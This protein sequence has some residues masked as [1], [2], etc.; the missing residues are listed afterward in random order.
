[1]RFSRGDCADAEHLQRC[2]VAEEVWRGLVSGAE[3]QRCRGG[4][5]VQR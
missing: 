1:M 5:E 2:R 4:G 3:V